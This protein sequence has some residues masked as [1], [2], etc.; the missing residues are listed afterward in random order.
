MPEVLTI[1]EAADFTRLKPA[2]LYSYVASRRV[3]YLKV[4]SRV[5]FSRAVITGVVRLGRRWAQE[6]PRSPRWPA[7][8]RTSLSDGHR[9]SVNFLGNFHEV[10]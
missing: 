7:N 2:T 4:G 8:P 10:W 6:I 5:L 1:R 3:P 9:T